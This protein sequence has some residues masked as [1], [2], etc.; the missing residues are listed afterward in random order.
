LRVADP[1]K[2]EQIF[3]GDVARFGESVTECEGEKKGNDE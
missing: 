1:D 3:F 2:I